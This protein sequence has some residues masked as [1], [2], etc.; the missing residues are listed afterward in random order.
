MDEESSHRRQ[1]GRANR[2]HRKRTGVNVNIDG[3]ATFGVRRDSPN[4]ILCTDAHTLVTD[5][6]IHAYSLTLPEEVIIHSFS[7]CNVNLGFSVM[8][9]YGA[10]ARVLARFGTAIDHDIMSVISQTK[11][12]SV[13]VEEYYLT[14]ENTAKWKPIILCISNNGPNDDIIP[15]G[16]VL[17][18]LHVYITCSPMLMLPYQDRSADA[19]IVENHTE[20]TTIADVDLSIPGLTEPPTNAKV[21]CDTADTHHSIVVRD[22]KEE[23]EIIPSSDIL[24][25]D[26]TYYVNVPER[27]GSVDELNTSSAMVR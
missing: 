19:S 23:E 17:G 9:P 8:L 18:I 10:S 27:P 16:T 4:A 14:G 25:A 11:Q 1:N 22:T 26:D 15:K 24:A 21:V 12:R 5:H 13:K 20:S 7:R 6:T 3:N 2:K